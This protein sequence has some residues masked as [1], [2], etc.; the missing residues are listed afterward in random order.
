MAGVGRCSRLRERPLHVYRTTVHFGYRLV[1][2][3][4]LRFEDPSELAPVPRID[5]PKR[6][7]IPNKLIGHYSGFQSRL[8]M[9]CSHSYS[10][11]QNVS[12]KLHPNHNKTWLNIFLCRESDTE[13]PACVL[14]SGLSYHV[15]RTAPAA[16]HFRYNKFQVLWFISMLCDHFR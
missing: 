10:A 12:S 1:R 13:E 6:L 3:S 8:I 2:Y 4:Y 9:N 7:V 5:T 15:F 14:G 16:R 11:N